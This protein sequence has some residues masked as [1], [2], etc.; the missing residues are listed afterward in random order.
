VKEDHGP[1]LA[2]IDDPGDDLLLAQSAQRNW[3]RR[4][5]GRLEP[6]G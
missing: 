3:L 2:D 4:Q 6:T 5:I 1:A